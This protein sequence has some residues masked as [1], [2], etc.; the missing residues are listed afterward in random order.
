[1]PYIETEVVKVK[2]Q[3]LRKRFPNWK[4]SV[5]RVN[6]TKISVT[7]QSGP[8]KIET[9]DK[10]GYEQV[11]HFYIDEWYKDQ[12]KLCK[13]LNEIKETIGAEQRELV[14]DGDYGSVPTYYIGI[15]IGSWDK[16]YVY[17]PS[18]K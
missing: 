6:G 17:K 14:Y 2:R 3:E 8:I 13:V 16:P 11:N 10:N 7:I 4:L 15:T 1:M 9:H 18:K 5:R 12:P